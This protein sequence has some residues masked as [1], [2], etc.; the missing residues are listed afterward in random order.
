MGR[1]LGP[2]NAMT[3]LSSFSGRNMGMDG[4][5]EKPRVPAHLYNA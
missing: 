1:P 2:I 3:R 4:L 5:K